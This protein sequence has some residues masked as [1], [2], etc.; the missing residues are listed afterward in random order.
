MEDEYLTLEKESTG[1]FRDKGSRFL[2]FAFPVSSEEEIKIKLEQL[3][4]E[5]HD[6]RHHCYA[7]RLGQDKILFRANDDGEPGNS[8]GK[9]ILGQIQ[10]FDLTNILI[11]VVRYF[12]GTLLGVGGLIQA[13]KTAAMEAVKNGEIIKASVYRYYRISFD[14][15]SMN[16]VM[17]II[18]DH[19]LLQ[20]DQNFE[21]NCS[22]KLA[23]R[24]SQSET[25]IEKLSNTAGCKYEFL[26]ER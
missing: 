18:K 7:W 14:Y 8:A 21:Q 13:Y 12:G 20:S 17:K 3:R 11:V 22:L 5:Y 10:S 2:A 25:I 19:D 23:V 1:I 24:K 6:A 16:Q 26:L 15:S 9:P 4:K